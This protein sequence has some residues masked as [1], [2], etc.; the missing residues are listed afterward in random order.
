LA[1][2][3]IPMAFQEFVFWIGEGGEKEVK[4]KKLYIEK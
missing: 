2:V 1:P 3:L 4:E